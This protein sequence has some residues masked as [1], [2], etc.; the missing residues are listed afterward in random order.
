MPVN[1]EQVATRAKWRSMGLALA[2]AFLSASLWHSPRFSPAIAQNTAVE[3]PARDTVVAYPVPPGKRYVNGLFNYGQ[4]NDSPAN[5]GTYYLEDVPDMNVIKIFAENGIDAIIMRGRLMAHGRHCP[6]PGDTDR[7]YTDKYFAMISITHIEYSYAS[8][9]DGGN[10]RVER[11]VAARIGFNNGGKDI[12]TCNPEISP[13]PAGAKDPIYVT[14][15]PEFPVPEEAGAS[16][17]AGGTRHLSDIA[18]PNG[19]YYFGVYKDT[20]GAWRLIRFPAARFPIPEAVPLGMRG[21]PDPPSAPHPT[22][23]PDATALDT[24]YIKDLFNYGQYNLDPENRGTYYLETEPDR[25]FLNIFVDNNIPVAVIKGKPDRYGTNCSRRENPDE[26]P[27]GDQRDNFNYMKGRRNVTDDYFAT[28]AVTEV[29]FSYSP[30]EETIS[31]IKAPAMNLSSYGVDDVEFSTEDLINQH[32]N[33]P[34][35]FYDNASIKL[36]NNI[37]K[38]KYSGESYDCLGAVTHYETVELK[39]NKVIAV[40]YGP[41]LAG[42]GWYNTPVGR[43]YT[44]HLWHMDEPDRYWGGGHLSHGHEYYFGI[45]EDIDG[46]WRLIRFPW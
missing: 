2:V 42:L 26:D 34:P 22:A 27:F 36:P 13:N 41:N 44:R 37:M 45:Y 10:T 24:D 28:L 31:T 39:K 23:M 32:R 5:Y 18:N 7:K 12:A 46:K 20:D 19:Q 29:V 3:N 6:E 25:D 30:D 11:I 17:G 21:Y 43:E 15:E 8:G 35:G 14:Y 16:V 1:P 33:D 9:R 40:V 38:N 4:Y